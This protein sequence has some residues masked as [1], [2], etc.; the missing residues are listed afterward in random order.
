M[1]QYSLICDK[2]H[3]FEAWFRNSE[4]FEHQRKIDIVCCPLCSSSNVKKA[5]MTPAIAKDNKSASKNTTDTPTEISKDN[6]IAVSAGH[7]QQ[8]KLRAA[9]KNLREIVAKEADYVGKDFAK[10][11]RK[12]HDQE[13]KPRGIYGEA[14][15]EEI[16][17]LAEDGIDFL[18]LPILPEEHN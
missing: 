3:K 4:A 9:I 2:N 16:S 11:A 7:P 15:H 13:A 14:T 6:K 18:P 1:I 17:S 5:L 12:I 10:E 8:E